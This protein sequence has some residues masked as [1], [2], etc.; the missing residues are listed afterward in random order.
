MLNTLF[1]YGTLRK[2]R[3]GSLHGLLKNRAIFLG[4][5]RMPGK[6]YQIS[7]YPGAVLTPVKHLTFVQGE[8]Y[9]LPQPKR[10]LQLLDEYEECTRLFTRP[11]EYQRKLVTV[12]PI[13]GLALPAWVYLYQRPINKQILIPEG[14][15]W[16]YLPYTH[17][18]P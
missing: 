9:R 15:Y 5:A 7:Y 6:L 4:Y 1:V 10:L 17:R 18:N 8:V 11:H 12:K 13:Y 2:A 3:D 16:A 14:D